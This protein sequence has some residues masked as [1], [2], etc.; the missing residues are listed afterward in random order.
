MVT[1]TELETAGVVVVDNHT[2]YRQFIDTAYNGECPMT[3][4]DHGIMREVI[5][6][7]EEDDARIV[8]EKRYPC[9]HC[10]GSGRGL[11]EEAVVEAARSMG[12]N[13]EDLV[14]D[15]IYSYLEALKA[16]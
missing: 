4:C 13:D 3:G 16:L 10:H 11:N 1:T 6:D 14:R 8:T 7:R 15:A 12:D 2:L 9:P 5:E